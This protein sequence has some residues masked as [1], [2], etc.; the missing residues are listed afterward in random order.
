MGVGADLALHFSPSLGIRIG[1][2][3]VPADISFDA[4][5]ISYEFDIPPRFTAVLDLHPGGSAFRISVG[6]MKAE[7]ISLTATLLGTV[8]VDI[9]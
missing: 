8:D 5:D 7:D 1:G 2:N 4:G 6:V 3:F 9:G